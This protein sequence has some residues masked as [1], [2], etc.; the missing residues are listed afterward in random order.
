MSISENAVGHKDQEILIRAFIMHVSNKLK[1]SQG[2]I[3]GMIRMSI[4]ESVKTHDKS[5]KELKALD[6]TTRDD[7]LLDTMGIFF[8]KMKLDLK[9][10][11]MLK[12][13]LLQIYERW[14]ATRRLEHSEDDT[15]SP[16]SISPNAYPE[17]T[18][19]D[20]GSAEASLMSE[21]D[22]LDLDGLGSEESPE[23]SDELD[24]SDL[25]KFMSNVDDLDEF[26]L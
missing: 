16:A 21:L 18:A 9:K 10:R 17:E 26:D 13:D 14:K 1:T 3:T 15:P 5:L 4:A 24:E 7:F 25:E 19:P 11:R 20:P 22:T 12:Y 2:I 6:E 8:E 23:N